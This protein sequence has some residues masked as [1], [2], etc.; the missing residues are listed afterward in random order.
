MY[1]DKPLE[2]DFLMALAVR[3]RFLGHCCQQGCP[4]FSSVFSD[5]TNVRC[6]EAKLSESSALLKVL[7]KTMKMF[8]IVSFEAGCMPLDCCP[9]VL[10]GVA[11][12]TNLLACN[13]ASS[14]TLDLLRPN[15][16]EDSGLPV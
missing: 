10:S 4:C 15:N 12:L 16:D 14:L 6:K 2:G 7:N 3:L 13:K 8:C 5:G 1:S 9:I 11:P